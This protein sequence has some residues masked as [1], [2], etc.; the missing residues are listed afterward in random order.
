MPMQPRP[1][2]ETVSPERPS[3]RVGMRASVMPP[4]CREAAEQLTG[5]HAAGLPTTPGQRGGLL[6]EQ[7][8]D[9][10]RQGVLAAE[11]HDL[12]VEVVTFE[13]RGAAGEALPCRPAATVA[14]LDGGPFDL[15]LAAL[16]PLLVGCPVDAFGPVDADRLVFGARVEVHHDLQI[17]LVEV[18]PAQRL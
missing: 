10:C 5:A 8:V 4:S 11:Q 13:G 3:A 9:R 14:A 1:C 15:L 6:L 16:H 7:G 17:V 2:M 18:M 12:A